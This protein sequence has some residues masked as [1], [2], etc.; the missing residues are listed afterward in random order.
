MVILHMAIE[1][2]HCHAA[3][4]R[5]NGNAQTHA[6]TSTSLLGVYENKISS[7]LMQ[8]KRVWSLVW[9]DSIACEPQPLSPCVTSA[10]ARSL[11]PAPQQE[12]PIYCNEEYPCSLQLQKTCAKQWK[13]N[14]ATKKKKNKNF[15]RFLK[16]Q[17]NK[18][19]NLWIWAVYSYILSRMDRC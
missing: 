7:L 6:K 3:L 1:K 9:W 5:K 12:K 13:P 17:P 10:E 19:Y 8:E 18:S 4:E 16:R 15:K 14:T 2:T 11:E